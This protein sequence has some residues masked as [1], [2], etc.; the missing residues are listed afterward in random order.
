MI[1]KTYGE[2]TVIEEFSKTNNK[3]VCANAH[4]EKWWK[5][6]DVMLKVGILRVVVA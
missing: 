3:N 4:V 2:L 1:G 5:S 6:Q